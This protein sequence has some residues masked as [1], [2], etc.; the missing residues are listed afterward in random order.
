MQM[1]DRFYQMFCPMV[2]GGAR[3]IGYKSNKELLNPYWGSQH[4]LGVVRPCAI[5]SRQPGILQ[6]AKETANYRQDDVHATS[7]Q[8]REPMIHDSP[9]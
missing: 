8:S 4:A 7:I 2:K 5:D 6:V 3:E 9:T 1:Q